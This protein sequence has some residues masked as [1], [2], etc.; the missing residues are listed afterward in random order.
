[1]NSK[2][3]GRRTQFKEKAYSNSVIKIYMKVTIK[4]VSRKDKACISLS[5]V[6]FMKVCGKS[7]KEMVMDQ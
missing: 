2:E 4:T 7:I 1:M 3:L 5:P 6:L